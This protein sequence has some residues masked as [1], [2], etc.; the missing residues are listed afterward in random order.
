MAQR[1]DLYSILTSYAKK[2]KYPYIDPNSF[3]PFLEMHAKRVAEEHPEWQKWTKDTSARFWTEV[4]DLAEEGQCD[5]LNDTSDGRI[6]LPHF[7]PELLKE[8]FLNIDNNVDLPFPSEDSMGITIPETRQR[9]LGVEYDLPNYLEEP[10]KEDLPIIRIGFPDEI[11]SALVL[12]SHIPQRIVEASLLKIRNYLRDRGNNEYTLHIL[13]PQLQG[14]VSLLKEMVNKIITRPLDCYKSIVDGSE[15]SYLFW[16]HFC[17]LVKKDI[18]KKKEPQSSD[19]AAIQAVYIIESV[20]SFYKGRAARAKEKELAFKSLELRLNKPPYIYTM[21]Q[22]LKFTDSKGVLLLGQ[23]SGDELSK[24]INSLTGSSKDDKLPELL[25]L[26]GQDNE[27]YFILKNKIL[28]VCARL[29]TEGREQVKNSI[30]RIW[31]TQLKNYHIEPAMENDRDFEKLLIQYTKKN[32]PLLDSLLEDPKFQLVYEELEQEQEIPPS[33][34]IFIRGVMIPYSTLFLLR[35]RDLLAD[36]RLLLPFWYSV[37]FIISIIAF[38]KNL[39]QKKRKTPPPSEGNDSDEQSHERS[40]REIINAAQELELSMVPQGHTIDTYLEELQSRWS[41]L[42]DKKARENLI[43]DVNTLVRDNLR[44][45]L[46]VQKHYKITMEN[47][48]QLAANI[49][50]RTPTLHGLGG[51]DS[52]RTYI[53]LYM[54]KLLQSPKF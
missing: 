32:C 54:I 4:A 29:L 3:I 18:K 6:Y 19:I 17:A 40:S 48:S 39:V 8:F 50:N 21:D 13:T 35:R 20:N 41:R 31:F 2:N 15:F 27:H 37:P 24:E 42:I 33:S 9:P 34:R 25:I 22:I 12:A 5:L 47:L 23:Y 36:V 16:G 11:G 1:T 43:I 49:L 51:K 44:Q 45:T 30:S 10:Q 52:I 53:E 46:R 26:A 38:F 14:K 28:L 7:Y